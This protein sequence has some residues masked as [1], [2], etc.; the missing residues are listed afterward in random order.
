[1]QFLRGQPCFLSCGRFYKYTFSV[2]FGGRRELMQA[3]EGNRW[4]IQRRR[5]YLA[6]TPKQERRLRQGAASAAPLLRRHMLEKLR[7]VACTVTCLLSEALF[8]G[9]FP[10]ATQFLGTRAHACVRHCCALHGDSY[11][12][13][14]ASGAVNVTESGS[15]C[16]HFPCM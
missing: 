13:Q 2:G 3:I 1:M 11:G 9:R 8:N 10:H 5:S 7:F 15:Q 6:C 4:H 14:Q 16:A 12:T